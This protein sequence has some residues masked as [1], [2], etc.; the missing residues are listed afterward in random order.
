L[1]DLLRQTK[2][3]GLGEILEQGVDISLK[4]DFSFLLKYR[5]FQCSSTSHF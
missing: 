1:L 3:F 5:R 2:L 4:K